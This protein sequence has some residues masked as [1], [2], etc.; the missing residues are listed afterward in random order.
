M[1][2]L[3][4]RLAMVPSDVRFGFCFC[5]TITHVPNHILEP[6]NKVAL[7]SCFTAYFA[8]ERTTKM[9]D[10]GFVAMG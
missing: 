6:E 5:L 8:G 2:K 1:L 4:F 3:R 10:T 9:V 7:V